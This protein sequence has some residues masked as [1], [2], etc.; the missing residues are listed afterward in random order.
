MAVPISQHSEPFPPLDVTP[1]TPTSLSGAPTVVVTGADNPNLLRPQSQK[2]SAFASAFSPRFEKA[3]ASPRATAVA[4]TGLAAMAENQK[5]RRQQK[6]SADSRQTSPNPGV[7]AVQSL[8]GGPGMSRPSDAPAPN[9]LSEP[10]RKAAEKIHIPHVTQ[11][12]SLQVSPVSIGSFG[13]A[14]ETSGIS[15]AMT[16]TANN[17]ASGP[18][19]V[20]EPLQMTERPTYPGSNGHLAVAGEDSNKAFS[21]PGPPPQMQDHEAGSSRGMSYP[22][23]QGSPKSPASNKRHKCPYCSTDFTRHHNL[24]SHLLTH[25][26]EKPYVCQTCQ[27]RFRRL[28]DLKRHT[29]LHTGERPHTCD[30]CG[31]RF[32]RGDALARHNKGPGGCAGRRSS[33]GGDDDFDGIEGMDGVDY[34]GGEDEDEND[35]PTGEDRR[36]SEPSRKRTQLETPQDSD[37]QVYRQH[38]STYPPPPMQNTRP[39]GS[40]VS[41]M[42][43]P[44][45]IHPGSSNAT[46][47]RELSGHHSP[48]PGSMSG[49]SYY[50]PYP[51]SARGV[52]FAPPVMMTE[53]PKPISPGQPPDQHRLSVDAAMG[54]QSRNRSPSLTTQF[55]Q[56]H[57]GRGSIGG[58][59][60]PPQSLAMP[61]NQHSLSGPV[62]PPLPSGGQPQ[63]RSSATN[64]LPGLPSSLHHQQL[65]PQHMPQSGSNPSSSS[66]HGRSS[67]SSIRDIIGHGGGDPDIWGYVRNLEQ[68][69]GKMQEEYELRIRNLQ[70]EVVTLKGQVAQGQGSG[71]GSYSS[72]MGGRGY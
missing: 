61:P 59:G 21:Y 58:R 71:G 14:M 11:D 41:S 46:S 45:I 42:G 48:A 30:K 36:G 56:Q 22:G 49:S 55:Q 52:P 5:S 44:Q 54:V 32:A 34:P 67:G 33:F 25:S 17:G 20:D 8:L 66:S 62:L 43:P 47:P 29:K 31:R 69:M 13:S 50:P 51:A 23:I 4:L 15:S 38:S 70:D 57:F 72:E 16:A 65:P 3:S 24:K 40:S 18:Q 63:A 19:Y 35:D 1:C 12:E 60:T 26:Q 9:K 2:P 10:L 28:H 37:R 6:P 68:R 53:S 64:N 39:H 27:S 7:Q